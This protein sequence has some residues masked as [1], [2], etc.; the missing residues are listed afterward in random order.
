MQA[1]CGACKLQPTKQNVVAMLLVTGQVRQNKPV[2]LPG[3]P[4]LEKRTA[5]SKTNE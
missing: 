3:R 2:F 5:L 4:A 1:K